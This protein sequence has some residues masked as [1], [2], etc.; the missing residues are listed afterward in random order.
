MILTWKKRIQLMNWTH[1]LSQSLL[2][3][4]NDSHYAGKGV[5]KMAGKSQ[6]L[7]NQVNDSHAQL[8]LLLSRKQNVSQS[9]L[10]QVN[11]SHRF[12]ILFKKSLFSVAIP[13]K[14]G[15]WFSRRILEE[16]SPQELKLSQ[17][18][19]NQVNDSHGDIEEGKK[20]FL[21]SRNPF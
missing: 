16:A 3:Q 15:Q 4:V 14:S 6:S 2:N 9:L 7:L 17:S 20:A 12:G 8:F 13:S 21:K 10:N 1:S 18:L 11:D 19:L 5:R